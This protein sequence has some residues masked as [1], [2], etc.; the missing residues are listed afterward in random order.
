[1]GPGS[2]VTGCYSV[3]T[4]LFLERLLSP[5]SLPETASHPLCFLFSP[6]PEA[7]QG[8]V[9]DNKTPRLEDHR[10]PSPRH[11]CSEPSL[12]HS[13]KWRPSKIS[14]L[15]SCG[16]R[17]QLEAALLLC[18]GLEGVEV[19]LAPQIPPVL[20]SSHPRGTSCP[21]FTSPHPPLTPPSPVTCPRQTF[22]PLLFQQL[23]SSSPFTCQVGR[24]Q[25]AQAGCTYGCAKPCAHAC[26]S[27]HTHVHA[28]NAQG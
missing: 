16:E 23:C 10:T 3:C 24:Q 4:W 21:L 19:T 17:Q 25:Q 7:S 28:C 18:Q 14:F 11:S 5:L 20:H 6:L 22:P 13:S 9:D 27:A 8:T 26:T 2:T 12:Q 15:L 1:M